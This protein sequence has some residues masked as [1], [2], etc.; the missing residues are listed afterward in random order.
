MIDILK[1]IDNDKVNDMENINNKFLWIEDD[2]LNLKINVSKLENKI[3]YYESFIKGILF[4]IGLSK[5]LSF[6]KS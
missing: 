6:L 1:T 4:A 3:D 2:I 5:I